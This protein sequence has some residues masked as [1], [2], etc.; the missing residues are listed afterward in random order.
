MHIAFHA[1]YITEDRREGP[2]DPSKLARYLGRYI[3][4]ESSIELTS[5]E[6]LP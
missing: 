4:R 1:Y 5:P 3:A 6:L 2:L